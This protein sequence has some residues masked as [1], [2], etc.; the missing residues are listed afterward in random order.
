MSPTDVFIKFLRYAIRKWVVSKTIIHYKHR[1]RQ[2]LKEN[3]GGSS[4]NAP[5][6]RG[7]DYYKFELKEK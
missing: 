2:Y 3:I 4:Y 6:T 5:F 1:W 7:K